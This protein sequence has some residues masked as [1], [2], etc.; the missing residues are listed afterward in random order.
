[1]RIIRVLYVTSSS[2]L[3]GDNKSLL[4]IL[5]ELNLK[6]V[7]PKVI[8]AS[9][10]K[11]CTE[12]D[13]RDVEYQIV[14]H[15]LS[16]YPPINTFRH[17]ILFIP[18]LIRNLLLNGIAI[19]KIQKIVGE[20]LPDLIH[21]NVGPVHV[22]FQVAKI[23]KV[24]HVWH[25]REYQNLD[26]G[27]NPFPSMK[28]FIRQ[29]NSKNN[30]SI[31]ITNG[32]YD[33]FK[34]SESTSCVINDGVLRADS[35]HFDY[36]KERYFLFVGRLEEAKG[37]DIL[38]EAFIRFS[39]TNSNYLLLIAGEGAPDYL[40]V[41][42]K[43]INKADIIQQIRF[44]GFRNDICNL[45][46]K[47]TALIVPS[48]F[49]GF[50]FITA[51]AMFNGCLVIGNN[52]GGTKEILE[53]ENLG[54]LYN[55]LDELVLTMQTVVQNGIE[56]YYPMIKKAQNKAMTFYSIERN[57]ESIYNLYKKILENKDGY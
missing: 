37:I 29:I 2:G 21:T 38:I 12:L 20:Y 32:I 50:G 13:A 51:E 34:M 54:I 27:W 17:S 16:V 26:F 52:S 9:Y 45:M 24:P 40:R 22:G 41:L 3:Y 43:R 30:Y 35:T 7:C 31:A 8:L 19:L 25:I 28:I 55:G 47:A 6:C 14:K 42:E 10:G 46:I 15:S 1:M 5:D 39:E 53:N 48:R 49:E 57:A 4:N 23:K 36:I 44:L 56:F 18:R 33:Y 11:I